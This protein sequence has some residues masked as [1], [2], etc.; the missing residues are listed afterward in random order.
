MLVQLYPLSPT[1]IFRQAP[2]AVDKIVPLVHILLTASQCY[3]F[4]VTG[5]TRSI[6]SHITCNIKNVIYM[7]QCN[8]CNLQY[9]GETKR[10]LKDRFNE[11]RREVDKTNIKSNKSL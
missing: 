1:I 9:V 10:P 3:T 2:S 11:H 6:T 5:E 7:F 4:H 8:R